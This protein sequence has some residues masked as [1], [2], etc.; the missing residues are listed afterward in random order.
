MRSFDRKTELGPLDGTP[1][2]R[3]FWSIISDY[4]LKTGLC[5]LIDNAIDTW[6]LAGK[7]EPLSIDISLDAERQLISVSDNAGGV[8]KEALHLLITP[9]GS[10]NSPDGQTIGIFGVGSKRAVVA[11]AERISINPDRIK[12]TL[13]MIG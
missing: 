4:D 11:I 5:E 1:E 3:L 12:L 10:N 13:T 8:K 7:P 6:N 2:K 9:G